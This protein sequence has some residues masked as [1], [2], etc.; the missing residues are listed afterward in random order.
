MN[1]PLSHQEAIERAL[2]HA[3]LALAGNLLD[4]A[5]D[6]V[7]E[8]LRRDP[9]HTQARLLEARIRLRRHEPRLALTA[10]DQHTYYEPGAGPGPTESAP[11]PHAVRP[12]VDML[13][14]TALA[15]AGRVDLATALAE[16]LA[17]RFPGDTG[18]LRALA[19]MQI[20]DGR[21]REAAETLA[22]VLELDPSDRA[23]ARLRSDLLTHAQPDAAL[24]ALGPIDDTNRRRAARLCVSCHRLPEAQAHYTHLLGELQDAQETDADLCCEAAEVSEQL[25]ENAQALDRLHAALED[26]RQ[27][28]AARALTLRRIARL[29]L[30]TGRP[31]QSGRAYYGAVRLTPDDPL[32]WAGLVFCAQQADKP[33]LVSRADR[34]LRRLTTRA[35]RRELLAELVPHAAAAPLAADTPTEAAALHS[36]LQRMLADAA[37]VMK[38]TASK[39][40]DRADVH[41]H[42]AV[43]DVARGETA[44]AARWVNHALTLNPRYAQAQTL[45]D[46]LTVAEPG[47]D[48]EFVS[49]DI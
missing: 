10:L 23:S 12:D 42:R 40:P 46:R 1:H 22:Q 47:P 6:H 3:Q 2:D 9:G 41:Y 25:G 14:A 30:H 15:A 29:Y 36:P 16:S 48:P 19:G 45:A 38:K 18:I 11:D 31:Q 44:D 39:Y 43:C 24:D 35:R 21:V 32:A 4:A 17:E 34:V 20:H 27:T 13:R 5:L 28:D 26:H 7:R 8:A 37:R 49:L 33:R